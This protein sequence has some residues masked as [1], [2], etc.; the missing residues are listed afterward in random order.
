MLLSEVGMED[1]TSI[2]ISG[3]DIYMSGL[4]CRSCSA[5]FLGSC[6]ATCALAANFSKALCGH[7]SPDEQCDS[8]FLTFPGELE[9]RDHLSSLLQDPDNVT[10]LTTNQHQFQALLDTSVISNQGIC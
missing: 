7:S 9:A 5:P 6:N 1:V 10:S 2:Y 4:T 8:P 3:R